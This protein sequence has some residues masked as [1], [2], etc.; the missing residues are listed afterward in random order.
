MSR[1][2]VYLG[3]A[4]TLHDPALAIV[5]E[6]GEV[7]FAEAAERFLQDKRAYDAPPDH[8]LR[9]ETLLAEHGLS[10]ARRVA[11]ISW[12]RSLLR[13]TRLLALLDWPGVG[14]LAERVLRRRDH[15]LWPL[16]D[17]RT[18]L[19]SLASSVQQASVNL[20]WRGGDA[21]LERRYYDHHLT[22]AANACFTS[23]FDEALCAVVDAFGEW[24]SSACFHYRDG[25]L[26]RLSARGARGSGR[27]ASL[28][29]FYGM[30]CAFCGFDPLLGEEWKVMG[31]AAHAK[32]DPRLYALMRPLLAVEGLEV[33]SGVS[34]REYR[35]RVERLAGERRPADAP[36][37]DAA[38]LAASGQ[39]VF[40]EVMHDLLRNLHATGRS[41]RLALA[42]GCALNSCCNGTLLAS[43]PFRALHVP[44]A[45]ADDGNAL[46][47]ALLARAEDGGAPRPWREWGSP[48]LGSRPDPRSLDALARS[49][50]FRR[51][52]HLP[53]RVAEAAAELLAQGRIV[54]WMQGRAEF[55]PRALGHRS[56]LAD[57]RQKQMRERVNRAVKFRED[58][59][60]LAPAI[61][62]EHG[63]DWFEDFV[64]S[65]C[66]ERTL[67][68][69]PEAAARVPAVVHADGT[70]RVQSVRPEWSPRF[71][72][73]LGHFH[74]H[75]GVP[76]LLNTSFNVMGRPIVHSVEDA[77]AVF[78][79]TDL[80]AL[81]IEDHLLRKERCA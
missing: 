28:G 61:L 65:P 2:T 57:P 35:A 71:H 36:P 22:H 34:D 74:R 10:D 42:G 21:P 32:P 41:D 13:R 44:S 46:G 50:A 48:F 12:S 3:L 31:L 52:E 19:T 6:A 39:R 29:S 14:R 53:G 63:P 24:G 60:P 72:A 78:A 33:V 76:L 81:V 4:A 26:E 9:T 43:T 47:A 58:F 20:G 45:P 73:L 38:P 5:T 66:M 62:A 25:R 49:G 37:L 80:D 23:P 8:L 56:I 79:T 68:F 54:G 27:R 7:V 75:T 1:P 40:E 69:R 18:L 15:L 51:V 77:I 70:G 59:R 16:A 11:A 64:E 67:R 30:L 17:S 55:G